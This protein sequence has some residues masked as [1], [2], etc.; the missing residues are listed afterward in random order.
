MVGKLHPASGG[1]W[2]STRPCTEVGVGVELGLGPAGQVPPVNPTHICIYINL[3]KKTEY[4]YV[5]LLSPLVSLFPHRPPFLF[6]FSH[7]L[8]SSFLSRLNGHSQW[9]FIILSF[10]SFL[11]SSSSL[12]SSFSVFKGHELWVYNYKTTAYRGSLWPKTT[13]V[14][15][16]P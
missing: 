6:I 12:S 3:K 10:L 5:I 8:F 15:V 7:L 9:T 11:F 4:K 13:V 14:T 16:D 2:V 1:G